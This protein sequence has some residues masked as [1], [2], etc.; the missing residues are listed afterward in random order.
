LRTARD[1]GLDDASTSGLCLF[2]TR[3][4]T[5]RGLVFV[6]LDR[7]ADPVPDL[8]DWLGDDF[9]EQCAGFPLESWEPSE[10]IEHV[11]YCNWKTYSD[12]YLEGYHIPFVHPALARSIDTSSYEVEVHGDWARHHAVA[13]DGA[14]STGVW[15]WHWPNLALNLYEHGASVERWDPLDPTRCRL[16]LDF[17][18]AET[19]DDAMARNRSDIEA[20]AQICLE[21]K[22]ICE[23]V[24]RNL[25]AGVYD[26]GELAPRHEAGVAAFQARLLVA[27]AAAVAP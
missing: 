26:H 4:A 24:Q 23:A 10:H 11:I 27:R 2:G 7:G 8:E 20:S 15:L 1:S 12:N 5:W 3:V 9:I 13:R 25:D 14:T 18:F 19:G 21:D 17:L 22:H 16:R 6:C